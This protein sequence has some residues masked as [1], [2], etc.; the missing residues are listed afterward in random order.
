MP[1][2]HKI[3][4]CDDEEKMR[5]SLGGLLRDSG[6]EVAV[7]GNGAGCLEMLAAQDFDLVILDIIM[8][9]MNGI[10]VLDRIQKMGKY[11]EAIMI[12][13]YADKEKA[14]ASFRLCAY[15]FIEKPFE[16]KEILNTISRC[17]G[18]MDLK[19]DLEKKTKELKESEEKY[20]RIFDESKDMIYITTW[21]GK[22][23][24]V[25]E[26]GVKLLGYDSKQEVLDMESAELLYHN[27]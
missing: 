24:D 20:R 25:N 16:P 26:A 17:L 14:I 15:D 21:G 6:Y 27:E 4:I 11:T 19:R 3:L 22:F 9:D 12:T 1:S 7:A 10:E 2:P 5:K 18:E 8:P 23:A 13:G